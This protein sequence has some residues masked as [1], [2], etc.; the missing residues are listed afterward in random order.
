MADNAISNYQSIM[1]E[2]NINNDFNSLYEEI[3]DLQNKIAETS[4]PYD[5]SDATN[6]FVEKKFQNNILKT[7]SG[8]YHNPNV[9]IDKCDTNT[10]EDGTKIVDVKKCGLYYNTKE[11]IKEIN[12]ENIKESFREYN[13]P[14]VE[15]TL[16]MVQRR[17]C[18]MTIS[19]I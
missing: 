15:V 8:K 5:S 14:F 3:T 16:K 2:K 19:I 9:Q 11:L 12:N 4:T 1:G 17:K 7:N 6:E 18:H 13:L 10:D